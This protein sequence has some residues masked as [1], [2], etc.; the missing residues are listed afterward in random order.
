MGSCNDFEKVVSPES[1]DILI[2]LKSQKP[3]GEL[4]EMFEGETGE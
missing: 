1:Y 3:V 4:I 2:L